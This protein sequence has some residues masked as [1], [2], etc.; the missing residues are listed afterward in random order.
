LKEL[1]TLN[2]YF[3]K[4]KW[5]LLAGIISVIIASIFQIF[6]AKYIR[7]ATN[8]VADALKQVNSTSENQSLY[9][10]LFYFQY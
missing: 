5:R 2:K 7:E 1:S 9:D 6:P 3:V 4:Y 10:K 8:F